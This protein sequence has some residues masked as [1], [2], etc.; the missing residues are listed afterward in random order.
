MTADLPRC[1]VCRV[2]IEPGQ[3]VLFRSD[4]RVQH[5]ACPEILCPVCSRPIL[6]SEPIRRDGDQVL[7]GNCWARRTATPEPRHVPPRRAVIQARLAAGTLPTSRPEKTWAGYGSGDPCDACG[8]RIAAGEVE[9]EVGV[10]DWPTALRV[11]PECLG[12]WRAQCAK[13]SRTISG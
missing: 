11:H 12:L 10:P 4:G 9:Y 6:P 8:E 7:H 2:P 1:A 13:E 5:V 3:N